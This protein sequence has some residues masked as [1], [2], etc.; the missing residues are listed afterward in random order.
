MAP[1]DLTH[2]TVAV[3]D[4]VFEVGAAMSAHEVMEQARAAVRSGGDFVQLRL[5]GERSVAVLVTSSTHV[6]ITESPVHPPVVPLM[7]PEVP[8]GLHLLE[9]Y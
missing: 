3:N 8:F 1:S 4:S 5:A 9:D 2:V 6:V 7:G